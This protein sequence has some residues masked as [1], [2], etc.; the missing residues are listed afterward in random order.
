MRTAQGQKIDI[1][2]AQGNIYSCSVLKSVRVRYF[3]IPMPISRLLLLMQFRMGSHALPV[4]QGRLAR[5]AIP[6]HLRC[7]N[8]CETKA[9]GDERHFVFDCPH[10]AHIRRQFRAL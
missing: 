9:F 3:E 6:R 2:I 8:L 5:P 7:C 4:E 1:Y 10:F